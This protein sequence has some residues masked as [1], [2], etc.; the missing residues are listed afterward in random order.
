MTPLV[1]VVIP[2]RDRPEALVECLEALARQTVTDIHA[3][4]VDDGSKQPVED[5]LPDDLRA[6]LSITV[7]RHP[8][9]RGPAAA[10]NRAIRHGVASYVAFVDDDV[11][12]EPDL[13]ERHLSVVRAGSDR[14]VS[15][16]PLS[17][18]PDWKPT[19]WNRWEALQVQAEYDRMEAGEYV[20]T[21]RQFHTGN[22]FLARTVLHA[23]G[24]FDERF[25]R[26]EDVELALRM[27]LRGYRFAFTAEAVGWHYAYRTLQAWL[28]IPR[29]Y[30]DFDVLLDRMHPSLGWLT[31]VRRERQQR[32]PIVRAAR[33][34]GRSSLLRALMTTGF[35]TG[36][37]I[38]H[39]GPGIGVAMGLLSVTYDLEYG[40]AQ[41]RSERDRARED[42]DRDTGAVPT[43]RPQLP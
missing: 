11:R 7:L 8:V 18:P 2:T 4:V 5:V 33:L 35:T 32:H 21:W 25:T 40:A 42:G 19:P 3:I 23:S 38:L 6:R 29:A 12:A 30:A 22:A 10:R 13:I 14:V 28:R 34:A 43:E 24:L 15:I 1:D 31:T 36:A 16:G 41:E 37:R 39:R 26:A 17:A 20:P 9:S 27:S